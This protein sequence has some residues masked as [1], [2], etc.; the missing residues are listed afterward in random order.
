MMRVCQAERLDAQRCTRRLSTLFH[1]FANV[2][3]VGSDRHSCLS[4]VDSID[5]SDWPHGPVQARMPVPTSVKYV[6]ELMRQ[7]T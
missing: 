7:S 4:R 2:F 3:C 5:D 6:S 1:K